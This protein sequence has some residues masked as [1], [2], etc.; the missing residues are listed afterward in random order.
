MTLSG[1]PSSVI[2][3]IV[4]SIL[5]SLAAF[6]LLAIIAR[7][8]ATNLWLVPGWLAAAAIAPALA[9]FFGVRL[10]ISAF[11]DM[12]TKG[13]GIGSVSAGM[14]EAMQPSLFAGY[15]A[16]ALAVITAILAVRAVINAEAPTSSSTGPA[17]TAI[18]LLIVA[19]LLVAFGAHLFDHLK[20]VIIDVIDPNG[21]KMAGVASTSQNIANL[22]TES[23]FVSVASV[24][25]LVGCVIVFAVMDPQ[26]PPSSGVGMFLTFASVLAVIGLVINLVSV[27]SWC[28]R[29][30]ETAVT[31]HIVR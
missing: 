15:V 18:A 12:A 10:I 22:L 23:A 5:P 1:V 9:A 25:F 20:T 6:G 11:A 24:T 7:L 29:L 26:S 30:Q 2:V 27:M 21:P 13:G 19:M 17:I 31:G 3:Y 8:R 16:C 4:V 28:S 14:W